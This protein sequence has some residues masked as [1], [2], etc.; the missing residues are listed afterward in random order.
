MP[1]AV[2][3]LCTSSDG[4]PTHP[5]SRHGGGSPDRK[6]PRNPGLLPP[7]HRGGA[8]VG[9]RAPVAT[10]REGSDLGAAAS[11]DVLR[12]GIDLVLHLDL[13]EPIVRYCHPKHAEIGPS[14]VQ[15]QE[16][17][18]FCRQGRAT[19]ISEKTRFKLL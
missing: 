13:L 11:H 3:P 17:T 6:R 7:D 15:S 10:P 8:P 19:I 5:A 1:P 18:M 14:K 16:F 4:D 12:D 9:P 2:R